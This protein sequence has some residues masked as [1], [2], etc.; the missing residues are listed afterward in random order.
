MEVGTSAQAEPEIHDDNELAETVVD[1]EACALH[2]SAFNSDAFQLTDQSD[3]EEMLLDDAQKDCNTTKRLQH[4]KKRSFRIHLQSEFTWLEKLSNNEFK[5]GLIFVVLTNLWKIVR[6]KS[7]SKKA[8]TRARTAKYDKAPRG[9]AR[10]RINYPMLECNVH[11]GK[12]IEL[13]MFD[14]NQNEDAICNQKKFSYRCTENV[15]DWCGCYTR[16]NDKFPPLKFFSDVTVQSPYKSPVLNDFDLGSSFFNPGNGTSTP[17]V[18]ATKNF[19]SSIE[20]LD[21][22]PIAKLLANFEENSSRSIDSDDHNHCLLSSD[23]STVD[24]HN[25]VRI[26]QTLVEDSQHKEEIS[27]KNRNLSPESGSIEHSRCVAIIDESPSQGGDRDFP[28]KPIVEKYR[29]I[30]LESSSSSDGENNV[31]RRPTLINKSVSK[32]DTFRPSISSKA[33]VSPF[34]KPSRVRQEV[35]SDYEDGSE[36]VKD[37]TDENDKNVSNVPLRLVEKSDINIDSSDSSIVEVPPLSDNLTSIKTGVED[38]SSKMQEIR[39]KNIS[40]GDSQS[41]KSDSTNQESE[42][43]LEHEHL[44]VLELRETLKSSLKNLQAALPKAN[45]LPDKGT[46]LKAKISDIEAQLENLDNDANITI[47]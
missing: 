39:V 42:D 25:C 44:M 17:F 47:F 15:S 9:A 5:T 8:A 31:I 23:N 2:N 6:A 45:S 30:R 24:K 33:Y 37:P 16:E 10:Y 40:T 22:K 43:K 32:I 41:L 7:V 3:D 34:H 18:A 13:Q 4:N 11:P 36:Q 35:S 26:N 46:R 28:K 20:T 1:I 12:P 14:R 19:K 21:A 27:P 29:R 38:I